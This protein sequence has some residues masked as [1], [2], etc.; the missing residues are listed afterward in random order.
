VACGVWRV[1]LRL[2]S[3]SHAPSRVCG[4]AVVVVLQTFAGWRLS[5]ADV[6][7]MLVASPRARHPSGP[8][9][10]GH[11]SP[12]LSPSPPARPPARPRTH[13]VISGAAAPR[14]GR[15]CGA[16]G[17][18]ARSHGAGTGVCVR[19]A[20]YTPC[21]QVACF[22]CVLLGEADWASGLCECADAGPASPAW[23]GEPA[24]DASAPPAA[25]AAD[26]VPEVAPAQWQP[27]F[28]A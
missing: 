10:V 16:R 8:A 18:R 5:A 21:A 4:V 9:G 13:R 15:G 1:C 7:A 2:I 14:V 22:L 25:E 6:H 23:V 20:T 27:S 26:N 12:A 11:W 28:D 19:A 24:G 17:R 3:S